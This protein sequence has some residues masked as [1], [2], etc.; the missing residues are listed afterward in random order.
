MEKEKSKGPGLTDWM[1]RKGASG[2]KSAMAEREGSDVKVAMAERQG[3]E[4]APFVPSWMEE[5]I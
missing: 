2:V 5:T 4:K 3:S 1:T